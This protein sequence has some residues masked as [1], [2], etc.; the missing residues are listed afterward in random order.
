M[1]NT[2]RQLVLRVKNFVQTSNGRYVLLARR[3]QYH[4][5]TSLMTRRGIRRRA[6]KR[7]KP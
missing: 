6:M 5:L 4:D 2:S 7:M 1:V 3:K